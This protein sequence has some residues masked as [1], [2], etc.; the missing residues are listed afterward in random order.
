MF[1]MEFFKI[2]DADKKGNFSHK[3]YIILVIYKLVTMKTY[4]FCS[5]SIYD[6]YIKGV[7]VLLAS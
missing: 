2:N 4:P 1:L 7:N 5:N 3:C 6:V